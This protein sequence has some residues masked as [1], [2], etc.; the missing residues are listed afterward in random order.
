MVIENKTLLILTVSGI[1]GLALG[2]VIG[3]LLGGRKDTILKAEKAAADARSI[4][5]DRQLGEKTTEL[6]RRG[7]EISRLQDRFR[8]SEAAKAEAVTKLGEIHVDINE[9][10]EQLEAKEGERVSYR[11]A[12]IEAE[13]KSVDLTA[14]NEA[15]LQQLQEQKQFLSEANEKLREAFASLSSEALQQNSSS[16]LQLAKQKL[17]EKVKDSSTEL[18]SRKIAIETLVKPLGESLQKF[19]EKLV[20]V[21]KERAEAYGGLTQLVEE[22]KGTTARLEDGTRSLVGAL[23]TSHTRGRY[24]EIALR[25]LIEVAGLVPYADFFDQPSVTTDDGRL[26]PDCAINLPNTHQLILDSKVPLTAYHAAF[27][28]EDENEKIDYFKR[29]AG[30][31]REHFNQLSKKSYWEAFADSPDF[32]IMYMHIE[33]SYGAA[34]M[35]DTALIEDAFDKKVVF[36]TPSTLLAILRTVGYMWQQERLEKNIL[37]VRDAGIELYKRTNKMLEHFSKVGSGLSAVV[38]NYN[39]ALGSMESRVIPQLE[40][41]KDI[42]QGLIKD[43]PNRP[44]HVDASVRQV[45]KQLTPIA[46]IAEDDLTSTEPSATN[47][48]S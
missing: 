5:L 10:R 8:E 47:V 40:R 15:I 17:D 48:F 25:R 7:E 26:R 22:M 21:E 38:T 13:K 3:Y 18:E 42:G 31:V 36:A 39:N 4:E 24:G 11:N 6:S 23:K 43:E 9:L 44:K 34:L 19:D 33:S 14:R 2:V 35:T 29:H 37:D 30:A 41:V 1:V 28:T 16:F 20:T 46:G 45:T 27:E 12:Q 32:V